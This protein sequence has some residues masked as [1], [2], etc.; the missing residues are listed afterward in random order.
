MTTQSE[1]LQ[2]VG[3]KNTFPEVSLIEPTQSGYL[4]L[5]IEVDHR[6]PI[7]FFVES[8]W[9]KKLLAQL[10]SFSI[11]LAKSDD[12]LDA[13]VFKALIVPPG[14]GAFLKKRPDVK[15][16]KFDVVM[17]V[18]FNTINAARNYQNSPEWV[19]LMADAKENAHNVMCISASNARRIGPVDHSTNGVF[20]FNYFYADSLDI[21]LQVWNYT[22]GWFQDQTGLDNSTVL[23]PDE[24]TQVPYTIINHCRWDR[25][26][27]I[28]PALLFNRSFKPFVLN[29]F[30]QNNTAA[31]PILYQLA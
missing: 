19:A 21:N 26:R 14:R 12:V 28:L 23:L 22:A 4:L 16:A 20:L 15:I 9:K 7:G 10:K 1:T 17:L 24:T 31:T 5:A 13:S 29:N 8:G 6:P 2:I 30:E 3:P 27:N 25:L 11:A 18:E